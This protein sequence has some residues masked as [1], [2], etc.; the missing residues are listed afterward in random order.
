MKEEHS[1]SRSARIVAAIALLALAIYPMGAAHAVQVDLDNG[2]TIFLDDGVVNVCK[3]EG[4]NLGACAC[5]VSIML[6]EEG[7]N[8]M[9]LTE[10]TRLAEAYPR[11]YSQARSQCI[12]VN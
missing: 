3:K 11:E 4:L 10:M 8:S 1:R 9:S 7:L 2:E 6:E 12:G 5:V